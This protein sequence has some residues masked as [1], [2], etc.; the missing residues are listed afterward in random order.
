MPTCETWVSAN[1]I[2]FLQA[3]REAGLKSV[4][5]QFWIRKEVSG[6]GLPQSEDVF[7]SFEVDSSLK[8]ND[9]T[10]KGCEK[11]AGGRSEAK[12]TG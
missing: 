3:D 8:C 4:G 11:V 6:K 2:R 10:R 1:Q 7:R 9:A 12:T 5:L